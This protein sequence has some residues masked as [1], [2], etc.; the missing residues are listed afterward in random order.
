MICLQSIHLVGKPILGFHNGAFC[1]LRSLKTL[2]L[3]S[4]AIKHM[5][6]LDPVKHTLTKLN[7]GHNDLIFIEPNY[8]S[9]F[10][11]LK[12]LNLNF[13]HLPVV[14]DITHLAGTLRR[15]DIMKN[16]VSSLKPFLWNVTYNT[17]TSLRV[18]HNNIEELT[19]RMIL[20]CSKLRYF[21]IEYNHLQTLGDLTGIVRESDNELKVILVYAAS[22]LSINF[23]DYILIIHE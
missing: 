18:D 17:L 3:I 20:S 15:F 6:P 1:G 12:T 9:G 19:P 22:T 8:F 14:P 2:V 16:S 10:P 21:A 23:G 4:C 13:N 5:P 11:C 7:L